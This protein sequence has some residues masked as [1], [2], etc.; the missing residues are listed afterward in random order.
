[1]TTEEY[2]LAQNL[3]SSIDRQNTRDI[4]KVID[5]EL[6]KIHGQSESVLLYPVIDRLPSE[7]VD[8]LAI[9]LHVDYYD[10]TLPL[11]ARRNLVKNSIRWHFRKGTA[12]I[13]QETVEAVWNGCEVKEWFDYEGVPFHFR[14]INITAAHIDDEVIRQVHRAIRATKNVR[15]WLDG[16]WFLREVDVAHYYGAILSCHHHYIIMPRKPQEGN[17]TATYYLGGNT[18]THKRQIVAPK[19]P[20]AGKIAIKPYAGAATAYH[21]KYVL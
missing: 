10:D 1:M 21:R 14:V 12:G 8:A 13:V 17:V 7:K 16:I 15:S 3:P 2:L 4:A 6:G 18:A 19:K 9:A 20:T 11:T 5:A